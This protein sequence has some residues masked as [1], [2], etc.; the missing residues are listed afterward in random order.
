MIDK[1]LLKCEHC[2]G[3]GYY[4]EGQRMSRF[5]EEV[6]EY[7]DYFERRQEQCP[8]CEGGY[9]TEGQYKKYQLDKLKE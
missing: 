1:E 8:Y 6:G 4:E 7:E 2:A 5:N 9:L 3:H